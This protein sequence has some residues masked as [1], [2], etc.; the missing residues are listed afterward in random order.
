MTFTLLFVC[1]GNICRSPMAERLFRARTDPAGPWATVSAGTGGLTGWEMDG[2]SA[3]VLRDLGGNGDEHRGQRLSPDLIAGAD[4]ILAAEAA[5]RAAIRQADPRAFGRSFTLREF[6]RLGAGLGPL[7]QPPSADDLHLRVAQVAARRAATPAAGPA[8]DDIAD[9]Y[10]APLEFVRACGSQTTA[11]VD[12]LI[13]ALG[14]RRV[15]R[16]TPDPLP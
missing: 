4:L 7:P 8:L 15:G 6:G 5:H 10:G 12:A 1:T 13:E 16:S 14:L 11:A 2:P 3:L 9:P